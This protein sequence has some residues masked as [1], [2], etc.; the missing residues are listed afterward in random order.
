MMIMMH[1][2]S[3]AKVALQVHAVGQVPYDGEEGAKDV[4]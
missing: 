3:L 4:E 1:N 2:Y